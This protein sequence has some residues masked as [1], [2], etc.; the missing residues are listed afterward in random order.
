MSSLSLVS[1]VVFNASDE[2][3]RELDFPL[4]SNCELDLRLQLNAKDWTEEFSDL[5]SD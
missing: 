4:R 3:D 1:V 2:T 5:A